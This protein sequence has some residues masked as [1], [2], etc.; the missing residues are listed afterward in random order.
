MHICLF[1]N[2]LPCILITTCVNHHV[3][4]S[5]PVCWTSTYV[6]TYEW[7]LNTCV[8]Y[9]AKYI[10]AIKNLQLLHI[11]IEL[12]LL[13]YY[14]FIVNTYKHL[15][16]TDPN[17]NVSSYG[18]RKLMQEPWHSSIIATTV[19]RQNL[20]CSIMGWNYKI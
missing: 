17:F 12:N 4:L 1:S 3:F 20:F 13:Y 5:F 9:V 19:F 6:Y 8:I 16:I 2:I 11:E 10:V 15:I 14:G 7:K 18:C